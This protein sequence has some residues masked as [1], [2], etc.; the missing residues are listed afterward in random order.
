MSSGVPEHKGE[1]SRDV[2]PVRQWKS[3][4]VHSGG[5]EGRCDGGANGRN[6]GLEL[7]C[8]Q[9]SCVPPHFLLGGSRGH[10]AQPQGGV[11]WQVS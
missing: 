4:S 7:G 11:E 3:M 1:V 9:P 6:P 8:F 5:C 10:G 2:M